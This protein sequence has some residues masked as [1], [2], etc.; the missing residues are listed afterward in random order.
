MWVSFV[1]WGAAGAVTPVDR[2][3]R[4]QR[5]AAPRPEGRV[6]LAGQPCRVLSNNGKGLALAGVVSVSTGGLNWGS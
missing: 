6:S 1:S 3:N 5:R 2:R 4:T